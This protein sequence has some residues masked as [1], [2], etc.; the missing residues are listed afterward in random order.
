MNCTCPNHK[1]SNKTELSRRDIALGLAS[2]SLVLMTGCATNPTT[3]RSQMAFIP[4]SQLMSLSLSAWNEVKAKTPLSKNTNYKSRVSA[5]GA[6]IASVAQIQNAQWEYEVF[7]DKAINAFVLPGGKV[8][9]YS[10]LMDLVQNDDQLAVVLS[11]ETGH[12]SGRHASERMSQGVVAQLGMVA[13]SVGA[14]KIPVSVAAQRD[15]VQALG[16]GVQYGIVLPFSRS[17][18]LEADIIGLRYMKNAGYDPR[19]SIALWQNMAAQAKSRPPEFL[20]THPSETTRIA[21]LQDE[22]RKMGYSV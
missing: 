18:E 2:G 7:E 5:V 12:V 20:S 21:R 14:Q 17:Q 1:F 4:D 6:R 10:G 8:G 9:V 3:G 16:L 13:A 11:H 22:L 19:Q 15:I